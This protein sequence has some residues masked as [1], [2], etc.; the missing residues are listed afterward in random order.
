M[1]PDGTLFYRNQMNRSE[2]L[3]SRPDD[4]CTVVVYGRPVVRPEERCNNSAGMPLKAMKR[5]T[6]RVISYRI[7]RMAWEARVES[8]EYFGY[9]YIYMAIDGSIELPSLIELRRRN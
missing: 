5:W 2:A 9:I 4:S 6:H 1:L 3:N 8:S 7:V